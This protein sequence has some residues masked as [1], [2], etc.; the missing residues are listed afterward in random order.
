MNTSIV[1]RKVYAVDAR[2]DQILGSGKILVTDGLGGTQ[3]LDFVGA[4]SNLG[5][6]DLVTM[7]NQIQS[8]L[9]GSIG[10][11]VPVL[12]STVQGLGSSSYVSSASLLST[13]EGVLIHIASNEQSNLISSVKGLGSSGYVSSASL[14]STTAS[15]VSQ[16][17]S[18]ATNQQANLT[19]TVRGLGSSGYVSSASLIS[20]TAGIVSQIGSGTTNQQANLISTVRGLGSSG[21][22]SS[23]SLVSTTTG[24]TNNQQTNLISTVAGLGSLGY[25]SSLIVVSTVEGLGSSG[26]FSSLSMVSTVQGLA[27][28]GYFSTLS[29]VSTVEGLGSSGYLS[30][31]SFVSTVQGLG[32][33]GY[34]SSLSFVSTVQGLGSSGYL[35][36][37]S[38]TSTVQGLGSSGYIST[39]DLVSTTAALATTS[40]IIRFDRN[41]QVT[42]IGGSSVFENTELVIYVSTF[43]TS[44]LTY[45]GNTGRILGTL[46]QNER[47]MTFSTATISLAPFSNYINSNSRISLDIYPNFAFSKLGTGASSPVILPISSFLQYSNTQYLETNTTSFLYAGNTR[48]LLENGIN[49]YVNASNF[50]ATPIKIQIPPNTVSNYSMNYNLV[51]HMP[52]SV[53]SGQLQNALHSNI[54]DVYFGTTGSIFISIQNIA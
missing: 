51:H 6:P 46:G 41:G 47:D 31:L 8:L 14:V 36:S 30:S 38:F 1:L 24:I 37:I 33:S 20:T 48:I 22:V 45:S 39:A 27:S 25:L 15:I 28:S 9:G 52:N 53:N 44:S 43:F 32:S 4:S 13:T 12:I 54:L 50:Y 18:G 34:L 35:S 19:S 21:Y 3:W 49:N 10:V 26:Y 16:L 42:V 5:G 2:T 23:A 40:G 11:T 17:A 7:N 29:M